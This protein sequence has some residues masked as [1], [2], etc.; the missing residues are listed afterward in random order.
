MFISIFAPCLNHG[1]GDVINLSGNLHFLFD[2][3]DG[4][5]QKFQTNNQGI[6]GVSQATG[7]KY[8]GTGVST[9]IFASK[10]GGT[11]TNTLQDSFHLIGQ[12]TSTNLLVHQSLHV[13]VNANGVQSAFVDNFSIE[14]K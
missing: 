10:L 2:D 12:G 7:Q 6:T 9:T 14:C 1:Q 5:H 8:V 11:F 3:S 4:V 13:T